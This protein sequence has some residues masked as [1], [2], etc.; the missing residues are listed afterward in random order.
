[1]SSILPMAKKM[2]PKKARKVEGHHITPKYLGGDP[3]GPKVDIN[4]AY[5][6]LVTNDF[7][8]DGRMEPGNIL[9]QMNLK[10]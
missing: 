7:V 5:H 6:Q 2:Y 8:P 3:N 10:I 1:M 9:H 4:G